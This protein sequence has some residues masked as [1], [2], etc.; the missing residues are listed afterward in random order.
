MSHDSD[1]L[2]NVGFKFFSDK[3]FERV[4]EIVCEKEFANMPAEVGLGDLV[5][6]PKK[7][8]EKLSERF[9]KENI[10][11]EFY[12]VKTDD[13]LSDE[14]FKAAWNKAASVYKWQPA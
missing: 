6:V 7:Y 2:K 3:D 10:K 13:D 11:F 5:I 12:E 1:R 9:K 8:Q 4:A 14:E